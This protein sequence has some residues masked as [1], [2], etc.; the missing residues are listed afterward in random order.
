MKCPYCE[1]PKSKV[2]DKRETQHSTAIRRRRECLNCSKRYTTY[3]KI[4]SITLF[5]IKK[6]GARQQ[7]D[8]AKLESGVIKACEKRPVS[9]EEITNLID[10]I[11]YHL[12]NKK[13]TEIQSSLIGRMVMTRLKKLDQVAYIRF[14]S[15]YREFKDAE[16]FTQELEKIK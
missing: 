13:T 14:A 2:V 8:R 3:E 16:E 11:E 10:E 9:G 7:F 1:D 5:I 15:V 12:R 6:D 4:E